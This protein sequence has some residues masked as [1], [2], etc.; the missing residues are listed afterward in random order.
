MSGPQTQDGVAVA[1]RPSRDGR[2]E[3]SVHPQG[4]GNERRLIV[5]PGAGAG[6]VEFLKRDHVGLAQVD[7][8]GDPLGRQYAVTA[9]A[10]ADVVTHDAQGSGTIHGTLRLGPAACGLA[11]A[12]VR[13]RER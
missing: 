4:A 3:L 1:L 13:L 7:D 10:V 11:F 5:V 9:E 12:S 8:L 6:H 2:V